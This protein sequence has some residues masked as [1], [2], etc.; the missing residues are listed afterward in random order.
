MEGEENKLSV[1]RI[2]NVLGKKSVCPTNCVVRMPLSYL[3]QRV[4]SMRFV[5]PP[6][7]GVDRWVLVRTGLLFGSLLVRGRILDPSFFGLL[8]IVDNFNLGWRTNF[9]VGPFTAFD[10][11]LFFKRFTRTGLHI[12]CVHKGQAT[13]RKTIVYGSLLKKMEL[14]LVESRRKRRKTRENGKLSCTEP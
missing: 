1:I 14:K 7:F 9:E 12:K 10:L 8:S 11:E 13:W 4:S 5:G 6:A 2:N 3:F